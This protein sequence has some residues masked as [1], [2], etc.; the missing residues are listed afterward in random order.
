MSRRLPIVLAI[1]AAGTAASFASGQ[2]VPGSGSVK[3]WEESRQA[4]E[5][6]KRWYVPPPYED[7]RLSAW[8]EEFKLSDEAHYVINAARRTYREAVTKLQQSSIREL[9][10]A[11]AGAFQY[12]PIRK[13]VIPRPGGELLD[14]LDERPN[15]I[16][17]FEDAERQ[18]FTT[19]ISLAPPQAL[20]ALRN[21]RHDRASELYELPTRIP[22]SDVDL[23]VILRSMEVDRGVDQ[24]LTELIEVYRT[25]REEL[26][27]QRHDLMQE[28]EQSAAWL[29]TD[30]GPG[31]RDILPKAEQVEVDR[32]F[33]DLDRRR[34]ATELPLRRLLRN[35]LELL[36]RNMAPETARKVRLSVLDE[37]NPTVFD[38]ERQFDSLATEL[39]QSAASP[40]QL[41]SAM[42]EA[43]DR[44]DRFLGG[45]ALK[46]VDATDRYLSLV[47]EAPDNIVGR[48][49]AEDDV[50]RIQADR[51]RILRETATQFV[52]YLSV[53]GRQSDARLQQYLTDLE[54]LE[55]ASDDRRDAIAGA[56]AYLTAPPPVPDSATPAAAGSSPEPPSEPPAEGSNEQ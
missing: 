19:A 43:I 38:D 25:R 49:Q 42:R 35:S 47:Y 16:R 40:E 6:H 48:L 1:V 13:E 46:Q 28:L 41:R 54:S 18:L 12:E 17:G 8:A 33:A 37:S 14:V 39:I 55:R 53:E 36:L 22:G 21:L 4:L 27:K 29:L 3:A 32:D 44:S 45:L 23:S 20:G 10:S 31:W 11:W 34:M 7:G 5:K 15:I 56:I 51:R 30:V 52:A 2:S 24:R 50:L 9:E 26:L